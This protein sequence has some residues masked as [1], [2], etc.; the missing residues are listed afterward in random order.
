MPNAIIGNPG[1]KNGTWEVEYSVDP[2]VGLRKT[3]SLTIMIAA[4]SSNTGEDDI[5]ATPGLPKLY[6]AAAGMWVK[7]VRLRDL[8]PGQHPITKTDTR[9]WSAT[10]EYDSETDTHSQEENPLQRPVIVSRD[11]VVQDER[12]YFD[13]QT[14]DPIQTAAGEPIMLTG[15]FVM[16]VFTFQRFEPYPYPDAAILALTNAVNNAPFRGAPIGTALMLKVTTQEVTIKNIRYEQ[17]TYRVQFRINPW[18]PSQQDT[19]AE[20]VPHQGTYFRDNVDPTKIVKFD[21]DRF[22][23]GTVFNLNPDG[24]NKGFADP[25]DDITFNRVRKVAFPVGL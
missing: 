20:A 18:N 21:V 9:I 22:V 8:G 11:T 23:P 15:P 12:I 4:E 6:D 7:R 16:P 17:V 10:V 24:T 14:G 19:W 5:A 13:A 3:A 25:P 1:I 2:K